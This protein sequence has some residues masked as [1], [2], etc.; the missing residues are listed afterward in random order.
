MNV[1]FEDDGQLKAGTVLA[2]ND[3]SLQVEAASRQAHRRS[4]P[5]ACCCAS[6]PG[7]G[8]CAG[9]GADARGRARSRFPVGGLRR[10]RVRL[11]RS[12][13]RVL[14]RARRAPAK[15]A[16]VAHAAARVADVLLQEG[17]G[18]L[19]QGAAGRAARRRSRRSSARRAKPSRSPRGSRELA[20]GTPARRAARASCRCCSTGRTRT[21]SS[22]RRSPRR[23]RRAGRIRVAL[24]A[25][26]GAIPSTHDY[27]F[28]ASVAEAFPQRHSPFR[29]G[30]RCR[31]CPSCRVADVRAFSIDDATTTEIDDAFSVRELANGNYEIGIHIAAPGA[32]RS[33]AAARSIAIAR[34]RL[35]TV[36]M[37]GR[38]I[39]MLPDDV[40]RRVHAGG[41]HRAAGAVAVRRDRRRTARRCAHARAS[42]ACRSPPTCASTRSTTRSRTRCR[43]RPSRRGPRELRVLWKLAQQLVGGARQDRRRPHRLQLRR[44]LGCGART[45][46]SAIVPR[47]ARLAARQARLRADDPRQQHVGTAARRRAASPGSTACR[48][49]ARCKM[50]T[51]PGEHQGLGLA[52]YLWASSPL[53]RYSDLVNQ[54]QLLAVVAGERAAVRATTT[55]SCSRR[56]P[57]SRRP[58]ASTPSSRTGWSTTGACAGCCRKTSP[59]RRRRVIRDNLVRFDAPAARRRGSPTCRRWPPDTRGP[60]RRS[61]AS[62]CSPRRSSAAMLG[63]A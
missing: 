51:R 30:A 41:R 1:L 43:R 4:R 18:P 37:P 22:G 40:D 45:A 28:N 5:A 42:S 26:C 12:R 23:A 9:R 52:H 35:S 53:R 7:A 46:A 8:R 13:A 19:P 15:P 3:A 2:D 27:H 10:R 61:A 25:A 29:R 32:R 17:Q 60:R 54:R 48:P 21:R 36:Y 20:A 44:R 49:A 62:T 58:T 33:R 47:A 55:P 50:S 11:R 6:P 31:P 16:A 38:K 63:T 34:A 39:T 14:R 57:T 59:R 24:L 56:S